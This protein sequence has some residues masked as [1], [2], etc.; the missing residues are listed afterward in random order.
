MTLEYT[1]TT[2]PSLQ[3]LMRHQCKLRRFYYS[4]SQKVITLSGR[5]FI[6]VSGVLFHYR[7]NIG[8]LLHYRAFF[9]SLS[10]TYYSVGRLLHYRLVQPVSDVSEKINKNTSMCSN[11]TNKILD[12]DHY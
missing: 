11:D 3:Q 9:M 2:D 10:G 7:P 4:I 1:R 5:R 12:A 8:H 6:T